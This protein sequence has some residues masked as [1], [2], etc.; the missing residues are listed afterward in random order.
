MSDPLWA[1]SDLAHPTAASPQPDHRPNVSSAGIPRDGERL[2]STSSSSSSDAVPPASVAG[3]GAPVEFPGPPTEATALQEAARPDSAIVPSDTALSGG[4]VPPA[5]EPSL[6]EPPVGLTAEVTLR[7][8]RAID[9]RLDRVIRLAQE[10]IDT[11]LFGAHPHAGL[12]R[13][14]HLRHALAVANTTDSP[15]ALKSWVR[16]Q[17]AR[18]DGRGWQHERFG[19]TLV[20]QLDGPLA[21]LAREVAAEAAAPAAEREAWLRLVRL[22][23]GYLAR[24]FAYREHERLERERERRGAPARAPA[25]APAGRGRAPGA[26]ATPRA[27]RPAPAASPAAPAPTTA[28]RPPAGSAGEASPQPGPPAE[29]PPAQPTATDQP[30]EGT[31]GPPEPTSWEEA[32]GV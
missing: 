24:H 16:Y 10:L 4:G 2:Q 17:V 29:A 1:A 25:P 31:P 23:L 6:V 26:G 3:S 21:E 7:L 19:L 12:L 14:S 27:A 5:P 11:K 32:R 30:R 28:E 15:E 22:H 13:E 18:P 20:E 9:R 8:H